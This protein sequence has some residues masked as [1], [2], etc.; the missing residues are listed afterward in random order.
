MG[1]PKR[2]IIKATRWRKEEAKQ[3]AALSEDMGISEG[4]V[5]R[6]LVKQRWERRAKK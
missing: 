3:L 4:A 5:V 2:D 6:L 1:L